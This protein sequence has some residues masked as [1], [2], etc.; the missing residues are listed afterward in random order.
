[1]AH[2]G[3]SKPFNVTRGW[4]EKEEEEKLRLNPI[5]DTKQENKVKK[6]TYEKGFIVNQ[7][8][9][10]AR[11]DSFYCCSTQTAKV[12]YVEDRAPL[13]LKALEPGAGWGSTFAPTPPPSGLCRKSTHKTK[14][15]CSIYITQLSL[16]FFSFQ[17]LHRIIRLFDIGAGLMLPL[18]RN[19][20]S[21]PFCPIFCDFYFA[22]DRRC[23]Y[24]SMPW[25]DGDDGGWM[26]YAFLL[27]LLWYGLKA[28][29]DDPRIMGRQQ[30]CENY[31]KAFGRK[32]SATDVCNVVAVRRP[33]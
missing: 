31:N 11:S 19:V 6:K 24:H 3:V 20:F 18:N 7:R 23:C 13:K 8:N 16:G 28:V 29:V 10:T 22:C 15:I 17:S 4:V 21:I 2:N 25:D 32:P 1:M 9:V 14:S 27:L 30:K 12:W 26:P 33:L 5:N